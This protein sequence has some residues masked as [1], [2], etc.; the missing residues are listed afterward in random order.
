MYR[1]CPLGITLSSYHALCITL[2]LQRP[3]IRSGAL[4]GIRLPINA[5]RVVLY[6]LIEVAAQVSSSSCSPSLSAERS[7]RLH[8][9]WL[10]SQ[11]RNPF[12]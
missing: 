10:L 7:S 3:N 4:G 2:V 6:R 5:G 9:S 8:R 1:N 11:R 12:P